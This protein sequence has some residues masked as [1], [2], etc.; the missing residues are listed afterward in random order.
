M[1]AS[2]NNLFTTET[3]GDEMAV[4]SFYDNQITGIASLRWTKRARLF[5]ID[6][7]PSVT[8]GARMMVITED[9]IGETQT[10]GDTTTTIVNEQ[11]DFT[12]TVSASLL[13]HITGHLQ[14]AL[15]YDAYFGDDASEDLLSFRLYFPF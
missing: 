14:A 12:T 5:N 9:Q 2:R 4:D 11:E 10:V 7:V 13:M 15:S 3:D 1:D 8:V 6:M